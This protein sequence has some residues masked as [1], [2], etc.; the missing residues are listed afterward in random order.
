MTLRFPTKNEFDRIRFMIRSV[1]EIV[2]MVLTMVA[3]ITVAL[4]H[5][6]G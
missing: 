3:V 6:Q 4:K 1:F 2:L 5:I